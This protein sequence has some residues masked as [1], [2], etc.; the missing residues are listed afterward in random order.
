MQTIMVFITRRVI[1]GFEVVTA[2]T[3]AKRLKCSY[4]TA[5]KKLRT[6]LAAGYARLL[7]ELPTG[8]RGRRQRVYAVGNFR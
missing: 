7:C 4:Q 8:R 3:L 2:R 6:L 5:A 1:V